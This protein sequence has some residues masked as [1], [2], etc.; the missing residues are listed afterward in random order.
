MRPVQCQIKRGEGKLAAI[1]HARSRE[2]G[3]VI[4]LSVAWEHVEVKQ[5]QGFAGRGIAHRPELEIVDPFI[6]RGDLFEFQPENPLINGKHSINY[7][8]EREKIPERFGID[9]KFLLLELVLIV[10]PV[11]SVDSGRSKSTV[12]GWLK[13]QLLH[14]LELSEFVRELGLDSGHKIIDVLLRGRAI[15]SHAWFGLKIVPRFIPDLERDLVS[16]VQHFV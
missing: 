6:G 16:Q 5:T 15:L 9:R 7:F 1:K 10:A 3:E 4:K 12:T 8:L 2:L 11:P 13:V 14:F